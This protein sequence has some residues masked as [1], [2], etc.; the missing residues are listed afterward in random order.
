MDGKLSL[1]SLLF[2][3]DNARRDLVC[4]FPHDISDDAVRTIATKNDVSSFNLAIEKC[5]L[6][7]ITDMFH[8]FHTASCL[9]IGFVW[10]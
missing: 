8:F 7:L 6:Y 2:R 1:T 3:R 4:V 5:D 10:K 9:D